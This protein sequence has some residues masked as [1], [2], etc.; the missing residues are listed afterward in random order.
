MVW[1]DH[2]ALNWIQDLKE[3]AARLVRWQL[4]LMGFDFEIVHKPGAVYEAPDA[5]SRLPTVKLGE[6]DIVDEVRT[7]RIWNIEDLIP[8]GIIIQPTDL[9][10]YWH[11]SAIVGDA[12]DDSNVLHVPNAKFTSAGV[13][14]GHVWS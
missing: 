14:K 3:S 12:N 2:Q 5:L 11:L 4:R 8:T 10:Q 7:Y 1:T 9:D 13:E 6:T